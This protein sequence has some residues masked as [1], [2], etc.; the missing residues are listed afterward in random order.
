MIRTEQYQKEWAV[1]TG[2]QSTDA[3]VPEAFRE[4]DSTAEQISALLEP[5]WADR[6]DCDPYGSDDEKEN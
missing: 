6:D 2:R 3:H 4:A 5:V 1:R